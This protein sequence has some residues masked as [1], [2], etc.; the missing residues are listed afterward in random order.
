[1]RR[2]NEDLNKTTKIKTTTKTREKKTPNKESGFES[3][4]LAMQQ[5][6]VNQNKRQSS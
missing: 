5:H 3:R 4:L 2:E 6:E 1:M